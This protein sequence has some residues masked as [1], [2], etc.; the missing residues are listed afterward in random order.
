MT[1]PSAVEAPTSIAPPTPTPVAPPAVKRRMAGAARG[2]LFVSPFLLT[3]AVT[4]AG[5]GAMGW[6]SS[7][8]A[9]PYGKQ[10]ENRYLALYHASPPTTAHAGADPDGAAL[11]AHHCARCHGV[12]GDGNGPT[13]LTPRARYFALERFKFTDT[14]NGQKRPQGKAGTLGGLPTDDILVELLRRG[15][16]GSPMPSFAELR[17]DELRSIAGYVRTRFLRPQSLVDGRDHA[18]MKQEEA[19]AIANEEDFDPKKDWPPK[20]TDKRAKYDENR[21]RWEQEALDDVTTSSRLQVPSPFPPATPGYEERAAKLFA[22]TG[23]GGCAGC[24]GDRGQGAPFD[25]KN[26]RLNDNGSLAFPRNF[27]A[28]VFRGGQEPEH[29]YRRIYLGIPGTPMWAFGLEQTDEKRRLTQQEIVDLVYF[30]KKLADNS[31]PPD[32]T[33][34]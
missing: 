22:S 17:D 24:H 5:V 14:L 15:I 6:L 7:D 32:P 28:G 10:E 23:K 16:P 20:K 19:K 1:A 13:P 27:T 11:Y 33:A 9:A 8:P 34:K 25:P 3:A 29:I 31:P 30:V 21:K 2:F 26:P 18:E 12:N 4:F